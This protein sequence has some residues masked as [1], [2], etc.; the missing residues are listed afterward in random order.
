MRSRTASGVG[1]T[2]G[3]FSKPSAGGSGT[4]S[5]FIHA[6]PANLG[7]DQFIDFLAIPQT[8]RHLRIR[9]SVASAANV[10]FRLQINGDTGHHYAWS[11]LLGASLTSA[12]HGNYTSTGEISIKLGST[13][14]TDGL[15][16]RLEIPE[17]SRDFNVPVL[18]NPNAGRAVFSEA[19]Y[20]V[21]GIQQYKNAG[22]VGNFDSFATNPVTSLRLFALSS[23][24]T[25][26]TSMTLELYDK[27]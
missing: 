10:D 18:S 15:I 4:G 1:R 16:F 5:L 24:L 6:T 14:G 8:Y 12:N 3:R 9:G 13:N 26:L 25:D 27:I 21:S 19:I 11:Q 2:R 7:V 17:Y 20:A 22:K 23:V